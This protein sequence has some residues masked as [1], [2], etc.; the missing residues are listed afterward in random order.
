MRKKLQ[1]IILL[2]IFLTPV[3]LCAFDYLSS[4]QYRRLSGNE[5][6]R[7]LEQLRTEYDSLLSRKVLG[8]LEAER[9]ELDIAELQARI[10]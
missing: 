9:L 6:A 2:V 3:F 8:D 5:R 1:I 10:A 4:E 7:Y